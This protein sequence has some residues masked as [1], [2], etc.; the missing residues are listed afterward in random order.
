MVVTRITTT[1]RAP[2]APVYDYEA[3]CGV[4]VG[5]RLATFRR[6][7]KPHWRNGGRSGRE[8]RRAVKVKV[9]RV[10]SRLLDVEQVQTL[11]EACRHQRHRF[12]LALLYETGMNNPNGARRPRHGIGVDLAAV[13][14][15]RPS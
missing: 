5:Q 15:G 7:S 10:A 4:A 11:L 14:T 1:H 6:M 12:L 2:R 9:P 8:R 13:T 3:T